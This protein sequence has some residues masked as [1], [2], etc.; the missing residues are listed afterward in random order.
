MYLVDRIKLQQAIASDPRALEF[1][2]AHLQSLPRVPSL[3]VTQ[4]NPTVI[5]GPQYQL[6]QYLERTGVVSYFR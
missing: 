6:G 4:S 3:D 5:E 2:V 1:L